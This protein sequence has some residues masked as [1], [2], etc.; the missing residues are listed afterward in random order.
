MLAISDVAAIAIDEMLASRKMPREAGVRLST[1]VDPVWGWYHDGPAV[2]MDLAVAPGDG[3]AVLAQAPVFVE[4]DTAALLERKLL[5]A[6]VSSEEV[7]FT[8]RSQ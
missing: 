5:D 8:L 3:D 7:R 1:T 4:A 6:D 2:Q